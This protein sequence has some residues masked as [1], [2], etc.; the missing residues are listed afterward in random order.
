MFKRLLGKERSDNRLLV[1][2][3]YGRIVAAAR[4]PTFYRDWRVPDTPLGRFEMLSL[5]VFLALDR[6]QD[7]G[8]AAG[9]LAQELIDRFFADVESS[10][11]ELGIGDMGVPKRIKKL[12]RMFYGRVSAYSEALQADD[13]DALAQALLRNAR[14]GDAVRDPAA[15]ALARYVQRLR[16]TLRDQPLE[17]I[18]A[19]TIVFPSPDAQEAVA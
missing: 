17:T 9:A 3:F 1:E 15:D 14:P 6:L 12:A 18:M 5:H 13:L 7:E 8:Q 10:L 4:Q 16:A 11:R 2:A 19:G